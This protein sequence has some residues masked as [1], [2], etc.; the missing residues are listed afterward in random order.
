M[1]VHTL[2]QLFVNGGGF[3]YV[4]SAMPCCSTN[5]TTL[6]MRSSTDMRARQ[7]SW[8]DWVTYLKSHSR[9]QRE[10][11]RETGCKVVS[12]QIRKIVFHRAEKNKMIWKNENRIKKMKKREINNASTAARNQDNRVL[13]GRYVLGAC[14][15]DERIGG[16]VAVM[17][18]ARL[19]ARVPRHGAWLVRWPRRRP[20]IRVPRRRSERLVAGLGCDVRKE[21]LGP[22]RHFLE[23]AHRSISHHARCVVGFVALQQ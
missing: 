9:E 13:L 16:D 12:C 1:F 5:V 3:T 18:A 22:T 2:P 19:E 10:E 8:N 14:L 20:V 17:L 4:L 21:R 7:R 6:S 15:C 11:N 23:P